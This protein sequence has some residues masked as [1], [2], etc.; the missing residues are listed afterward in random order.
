MIWAFWFSEIASG[1]ISNT[2]HAMFKGK[3]I[4]AAME[5]I[6]DAFY[7]ALAD[8]QNITLL[9]TDFCKAY[10]YGNHNALIYILKRLKAPP[11]AIFVIEKVLH[12]SKTWLPSIGGKSGSSP[13]DSLT[14]K[15][16]V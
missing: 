6:Y 4:D 7:E 2:Q 15:T 1:V 8:R 9:Q 16:R 13:A 14:S 11:Q 12:P 10:D 5:T 3:S